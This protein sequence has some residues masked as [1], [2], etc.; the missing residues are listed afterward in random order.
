MKVKVWNENIYVYEED[1]RGK[2][3]SIAPKGF[4]ELEEDEA[5]IF[6]GTIGKGPRKDTHGNFDPR[7][8]KKLRME[9]PPRNPSDSSGGKALDAIPSD[10]LSKLVESLVEKR[11]SEMNKAPSKQA[12]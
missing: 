12:K 8:F 9:V 10:Q 5:H 3:I 11:M 2:K 4:I 1:F 7:F 6:F